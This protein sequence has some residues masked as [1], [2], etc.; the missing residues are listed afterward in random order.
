MSLISHNFAN[1]FRIL[2]NLP[3]NH[4]KIY[5]SPSKQIGVTSIEF[6]VCLSQQQLSS[7]CYCLGLWKWG[8]GCSNFFIV[9]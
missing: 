1:P 2:R 4:P 8:R 5:K 6:L 3:K 7:G 9:L